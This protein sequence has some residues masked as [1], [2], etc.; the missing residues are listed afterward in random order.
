MTSPMLEAGCTL[1]VLLGL[2]GF[3]CYW[4]ASRADLVAGARRTANHPDGEAP[5][6][7]TRAR[8]AL[9]ASGAIALGLIATAL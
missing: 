7:R 4:E 6:Y 8:V 3:L 5:S 9:A 2:Y 1:V